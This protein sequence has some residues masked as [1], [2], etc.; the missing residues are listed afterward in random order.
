MVHLSVQ[1]SFINP[2]FLNTRCSLQPVQSHVS[3]HLSSDS[4]CSFSS[5]GHFFPA[6][7]DSRDRWGWFVSV[8]G[9]EPKLLGGEVF[10]HSELS[11]Q[12]PNPSKMMETVLRLGAK[13]LALDDGFLYSVNSNCSC[14]Q[15]HK[16]F[17]MFL[18]PAPV[19]LVAVHP[20]LHWCSCPGGITCTWCFP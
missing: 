3:G 2:V 19:V 6:G 7:H 15:H 12:V 14:T 9:G 16:S 13:E 8:R 18:I 4:C 1:S 11:E 10:C 5:F 20:S 17:Y